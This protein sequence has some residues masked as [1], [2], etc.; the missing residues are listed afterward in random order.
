[1]NFAIDIADDMLKTDIRKKYL[2][3]QS[4]K[5]VVP[6]KGIKG[7]S[8]LFGLSSQFYYKNKTSRIKRNTDLIIV[9]DIV[10]CIRCKMPRIGTRKLYYLVKDELNVLHIKIG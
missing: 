7:I 1:M 6:I 5:A 3:K 4:K 8:I 9:R 10:M 2:P